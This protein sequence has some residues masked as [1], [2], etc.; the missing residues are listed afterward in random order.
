MKATIFFLAIIV[1]AWL[2]DNEHATLAIFLWFIAAAELINETWWQPRS[3]R[4]KAKWHERVDRL[5]LAL[6]RMPPTARVA[7]DWAGVAL[8]V[9]AFGALVYFVV[10]IVEPSNP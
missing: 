6:R 9:I 8:V 1:G 10:R 2:F 3:A 5:Y 4:I 7:I